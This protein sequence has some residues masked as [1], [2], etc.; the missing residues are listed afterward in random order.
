VRE[1]KRGK[2]KERAGERRGERRGAMRGK[3]GDWVGLSAGNGNDVWQLVA[4]VCR[5]LFCDTKKQHLKVW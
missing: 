4:I 3:E 1:K 5:R 2:R